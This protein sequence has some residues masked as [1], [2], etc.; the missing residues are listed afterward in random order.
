M[1]KLTGILILRILKSYKI[2]IFMALNI[3]L[4]GSYFI[5][6]GVSHEKEFILSPL[7]RYNID[8]FRN[9]IQIISFAESIYYIPL[10]ILL[11][12]FILFEVVKN[13]GTNNANG[14]LLTHI[15]RPVS[16]CAYFFTLF[17]A[18][19][20]AF[21]VVSLFN[22]IISYCLFI[23]NFGFHNEAL[24]KL[25]LASILYAVWHILVIISC[26]T[27]I[28]IMVKRIELAVIISGVLMVGASF[29]FILKDY[30]IEVSHYY[31]TDLIRLVVP[32][33]IVDAYPYL[34]TV[35]HL[36]Q[37]FDERTPMRLLEFYHK[38]G[39]SVSY[40]PDPDNGFSFFKVSRLD[41]LIEGIVLITI[42]ILNGVL[43]YLSM[44]KFK[45][46]DITGD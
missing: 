32:F 12:L 15:T 8:H 31:N 22:I 4:T 20:I 39:L 46:M 45:R 7:F 10:G 28:V 40:T 17:I 42:P 30:L 5:F 35:R 3:I 41:R 23:L 37:V 24:I 43:L 29:S 19:F 18:L 9:I 38:F 6:A 13:F 33:T 26:L 34:F 2:Y 44:V 14:V 16:R 21:L 25:V 1:I 27:F 11:W 36:F